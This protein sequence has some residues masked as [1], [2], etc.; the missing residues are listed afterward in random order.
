MV[1]MG[2]HRSLHGKRQKDMIFNGVNRV[3]HCRTWPPTFL[4]GVLKQAYAK[5]VFTEDELFLIRDLACQF[6]FI[7]DYETELA[8]QILCK[9]LIDLMTTKAV[10]ERLTT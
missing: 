1:P 7:V 9:R 3:G 5:P 8:D 4:L 10:T 6:Q 2:R